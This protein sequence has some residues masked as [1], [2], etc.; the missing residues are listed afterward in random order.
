MCALFSLKYAQS[1]HSNTCWLACCHL[2]LWLETRLKMIRSHIPFQSSHKIARIEDPW[3]PAK[4][5]ANLPEI[6]RMFMKVLWVRPETL[7]CFCEMYVSNVSCLLDSYSLCRSE[8]P[9]KILDTIPDCAVLV[10]S[11]W[12][13]RK[14]AWTLNKISEVASWML[15]M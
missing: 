10:W 4:I 1:C 6:L 15:S 2:W 3:V 9:S 5:T 13:V 12:P 8:C 14:K 7:P 11:H